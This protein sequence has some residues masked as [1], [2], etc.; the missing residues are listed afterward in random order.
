M[1]YKPG[2]GCARRAPGYGVCG[3]VAAERRR[4]R[5][6]HLEARALR[7]DV[8]LALLLVERFPPH[9]A[10]RHR[11]LLALVVQ[12]ASPPAPPLRSVT[13]S[14]A[15]RRSSGLTLSDQKYRAAPLLGLN[16]Q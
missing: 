6:A 10:Q 7:H 4:G 11:P 13:K 2:A 9:N 16:A 5:G 1:Q 15:R 12:L 8:C 3:F 14:T